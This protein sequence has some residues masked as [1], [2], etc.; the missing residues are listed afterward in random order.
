[1]IVDHKWITHTAIDHADRLPLR[2][3][4]KL[5]HDRITSCGLQQRE[6]RAGLRRKAKR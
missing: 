1:M 5:P 3:I 2:Q 6:R 4:G